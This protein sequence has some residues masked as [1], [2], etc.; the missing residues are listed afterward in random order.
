MGRSSS[1][2]GRSG[3]G[4]F[5][6]GGRS[7]GGFSGGSSSGGRSF[8][9]SSR[10]SSGGGFRFPVIINAPRYSNSSGG[11]GV[12]PSQNGGA[13]Q[14]SPEGSKGCGFQILVVAIVIILLLVLIGGM[15]NCSS[16]SSV[17]S[18]TVEREA[19]PASATSETA[20]YTDEDGDWIH[21]TNK[22]ESGL[23]SFYRETGVQPYVYIL[24]NGQTSSTAEL[25]SFAEEKYDELF[26]D[27][28]HFL[29]VFCD[30]NQGSY[31]C[32][33]VVGSQAKTVMDSEAINVLNDYIDRYYSDLSLSEEDI[34]SKAFADTGTRIMTVTQSP[35]IPILICITIIAVVIGVL[36]IVKIRRDQ[37]ERE[38]EHTEQILSTPL[39]K[40]GDK[41]LDDLEKKYEDTI[42]AREKT[43]ASSQT[44]EQ[45][46]SPNNQT[47][48]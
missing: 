27:E 8:G 1:G 19:L 25:T 32:G 12:P 3:G 34:F 29:L 6:G 44:Q 17:A 5:S 48:A 47:G 45:D 21:D 41:K 2:G 31:H 30:D 9:G 46:E 24:P 38:Q 13:P 43:P 7:S 35:L 36:F 20:Y 10:G 11:G 15:S 37:R 40:F 39:E 4:G 14:N 42:P 26:N 16:D 22:F 23:K 33:Y 18:S 28:G